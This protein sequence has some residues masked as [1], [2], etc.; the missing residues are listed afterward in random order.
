MARKRRGFGAV[1]YSKGKFL[2]KGEVRAA[3]RELRVIGR[4]LPRLGYCTTSLPRDHFPAKELCRIHV[5]H[6]PTGYFWVGP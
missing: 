5:T 6:H 1:S 2:T 3:S 4:K